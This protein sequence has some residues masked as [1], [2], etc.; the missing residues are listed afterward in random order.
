MGQ[1]INNAMKYKEEDLK[2]ICNL[3]AQSTSIFNEKGIELLF[4][5][6]Y[7]KNPDSENHNI[8][9]A[10]ISEYLYAHPGENSKTIP[11]L[12]FD[13]EA[14]KKK[15]SIKKKT[16]I[17]KFNV[18]FGI[19]TKD[20]NK[21]LPKRIYIDKH[22]YCRIQWNSIIRLLKKYNKTTEYFNDFLRTANLV[23]FIYIE[24]KS[25]LNFSSEQ[26]YEQV[27]KALSK[28]LYFKTTIYASDEEEASS[29]A[30]S[31]FKRVL[32]AAVSA[33]V[34]SYQDTTWSRSGILKRR[35][36]AMFNGVFI[37][38]DELHNKLHL[39]ESDEK[40]LTADQ[41]LLQTSP[42]KNKLIINHY[43]NILN[44]TNKNDLNPVEKRLLS[45]NN[46]L[47]DSLSSRN[48]ANRQLGLW[49]TIESGITWNNCRE[50]DIIN[51]LKSFYDMGN[52][53]NIVWSLIGDYILEKR[54]L[55][56][57]EGKTLNRDSHG[58]YDTTLNLYLDY[59]RSELKIILFLAKGKPKIESNADYEIFMKS[60]GF[61]KK[62][63]K[64]AEWIS[65]N[66]NYQ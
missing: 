25:K 50:K 44:H 42:K 65:K 38:L 18:L 8:F 31:D 66:R 21:Y 6:M 22:N 55:Y 16:Q 37:V 28:N 46:I 49:Q 13:S 19:A 54:G 26:F 53:E 48:I 11:P 3:Y 32:S 57:H 12:L 33:Y 63:L 61:K 43:K 59:I 2:Y 58:S 39:P 17:R 20:G 15:I 9:S 24:D 4:Y 34:L 14:I 1:R 23:D 60:Y 51:T 7:G 5:A 47:Y 35:S 41:E 64:I 40:I 29:V 62:N 27:E 10:V 45:I 30:E 52:R 56:V 36:P